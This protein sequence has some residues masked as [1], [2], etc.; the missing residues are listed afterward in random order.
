[1]NR[2]GQTDM[3]DLVLKSGTIHFLAILDFFFHYFYRHNNK[4]EFYKFELGNFG[5]PHP[6]LCNHYSL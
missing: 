6:V 1:M 5:L 3:Y 2:N 4:G